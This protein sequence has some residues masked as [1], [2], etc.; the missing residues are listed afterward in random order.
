MLHVKFLAQRLACR[1][2][3][4]NLLGSQSLTVKPVC[5]AIFSLVP[6]VDGI[7]DLQYEEI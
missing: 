4:I 1:K 6:R 5:I 2:H 7:A 3:L